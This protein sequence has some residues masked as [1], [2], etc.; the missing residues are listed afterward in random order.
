MNNNTARRIFGKGTKARKRYI[1][2]EEK[3]RVTRF[4]TTSI[5]SEHA[6]KNI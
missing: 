4:L 3:F 6:E 2:D 5:K 1:E